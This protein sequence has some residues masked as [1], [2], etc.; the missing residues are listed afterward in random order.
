MHEKLEE[1]NDTNCRLHAV[2]N[3]NSIYTYTKIYCDKFVFDN[4]QHN[5]TNRSKQLKCIVL[6]KVKA[7]IGATE[8]TA[9]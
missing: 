9:C 5:K 1:N 7:I 2:R 6:G 8:L 3:I 4:N